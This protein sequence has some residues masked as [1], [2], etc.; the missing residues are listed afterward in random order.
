[1]K[2]KNMQIEMVYRELSEIFRDIFMRD[3]LIIISTLSSKD[4]EDWDSFKMIE[5][6]MAIEEQFNVKL[7]T[8][9]VDGLRS[10]GDLANVIFNKVSSR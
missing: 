4:V 7:S 2:A 1:L 3:D 6:I 8:K 9:E 10:V 5:I